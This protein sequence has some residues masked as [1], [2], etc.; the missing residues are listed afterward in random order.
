MSLFTLNGGL[1]VYK[2]G[3]SGAANGIPFGIF[4]VL[5]G[6]SALMLI[7]VNLLAF[8]A[9]VYSISYME[10]YTDKTRFYTL[11]LLMT[12]GMNGVVLSGDM[13]NIFVFLELAAIAS[14]A[15]VAFGTDAEELEAAYKYQVMGTMASLL[16]LLGIA[17]LYSLTGTL[18]MADTARIIGKT[19]LTTPVL[20][21]AAIFFMGFGLKGALVPFHAWLPDAHPS[22]PAPISAMLSG[23]VIKVLGVYAL[24]RILFNVLGLGAS[25]VV[26]YL[27]MII[28][29]ISMFLGALLA[30]GQRDFKR[31]LAYSSISQ[32]GFIIFAFGLGTP[33]G[34]LGGAF[35]LLNHA[36][37]KGL[38]FL[39]SGAVVYSANTRDLQ[40]MGGLNK[41]MPITGTTSMIGSMAISGIPPFSGFWSKLI[42][43]IA[44]VQANHMVFAILAV[45]ASIITLAYYLKVQKFAF[46]GKLNEKLSAIKE[47]PLS[48]C[49]S[50]IMLALMCIILSFI[51]LPQLR[52]VFLDPAVKVLQQG[53]NYAN[54]V[55]GS[56]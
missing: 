18:N 45:V 13:F 16:I 27:L 36:V 23:V 55:I 19:G 42:I 53:T 28:G 5:D 9:C 44:A 25:N 7:I 20:I 48:M 14:Y 15:L 56:L 12:A 33:L 34:F 17:I 30:I 31:L 50:M 54:A 11:F 4:L 22:A 49:I 52:A 37:S 32:I 3:G 24:I 38:L 1:V 29:T 21:C 46:F 6:L 8:F 10:K 40:E 2:L 26:L 43:I 41:R 35:H 51:L 39:N 47:V